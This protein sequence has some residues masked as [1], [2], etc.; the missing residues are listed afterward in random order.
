MK[1]IVFVTIAGCFLMA[2]LHAQSGSDS[3]LNFLLKNKNRAS[4]YLQKN[5]YILTKLNEDKL[6]PLAGAAN[7]MVAVEFAKQAAYNVFGFNALV[8][9]KDIN[10]YYL[11]NTDGDAYRN[12]IKYETR[13]GHIKND[14]IKLI[15][16]ARGM[17]MYGSTANAE[18]LME[19]LGFGNLKNDIRMFGLKQHTLLY[20]MPSSLFLYQ[21]PKGLAEDKILKEIQSLKEDDYYKAVFSIHR[22]L[23]MD[24]G[25]KEKFRPQ[26]L[27]IKMQKAW[28][29]RLT[30]ATAKEYAKVARVINARLILNEKSYA[31]LGKLVETLMESPSSKTWLKHVGM[32]G[33][34]TISVLTKTVYA[35]LK[36]G[37][38]LELVYFFNDLTGK[39]T[40]KLQSWMN[41]FDS[42]ILKDENFRKKL[43]EGVEGKKK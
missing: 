15:D 5:D 18:Y 1:K 4:L 8:P 10:K 28:S 34:S 9:L 38:K 41:D 35:T 36:D 32:F 12:W 43:V 31:V 13:I 39:E 21:N 19:L 22:E 30:A 29:A 40:Y 16:V 24:S 17:I 23:N 26:D 3:L 25:Y 20:P 7:I 2:S 42:R 37:T 6:M 14:S 27:S 33:G 11:P